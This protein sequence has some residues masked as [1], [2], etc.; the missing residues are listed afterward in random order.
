VGTPAA[1][2]PLNLPRLDAGTDPGDVRALA[3]PTRLPAEEAME[4]L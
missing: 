4:K 2:I 1:E 3:L